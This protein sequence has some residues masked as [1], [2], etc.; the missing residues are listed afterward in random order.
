MAAF[1][2]KSTTD[3]SF[4]RKTKG[5]YKTD[6]GIDISFHYRI[7]LPERLIV[8]KFILGR[9]SR[10]WRETWRFVFSDSFPLPQQDMNKTRRRLSVP[11]DNAINTELL[12][13]NDDEAEKIE[14]RKS[15]P[16]SSF[17]TTILKQTAQNKDTNKSHA[18]KQNS[19]STQSTLTNQQLAELYAN[20][21]KL[22]NENKINQKNTWS[23]KL[24]DYIDDVIAHQENQQDTAIGTNFQA[25]S[26]TLDA[27]VK[28]YSH[29][30]DSVHNAA[31]QMLGGLVRAESKEGEI[32]K[33]DVTSKIQDNET[34]EKE[35]TNQE[36]ES[37]DK[38]AEKLIK[39]GKT[40][41]RGVNT[42]ETNLSN[43]N[44][45]KIDLEFSVDPLFRKTSA[46]FD[47]GGAHGLLLNRL[48]VYNGCTLIFDSSDALDDIN[49]GASVTSPWQATISSNT[50]LIS[51]AET[52]SRI[53]KEIDNLEICPHFRDFKFFEQTKDLQEVT[54]TSENEAHHHNNTDVV[55]AI[56][57]N[58]VGSDNHHAMEENEQKSDFWGGISEVSN[59]IEF[60]EA[61]LQEQIQKQLFPAVANS[62]PT[63]QKG[64]PL[65][66]D[67]L[68]GGNDGKNADYSYFDPKLLQNWAGPAHWKFK[69]RSFSF[70]LFTKNFS[71]NRSLSS[72]SFLT[73]FDILQKRQ[74]MKQQ[75]AC[76]LL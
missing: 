7:N 12:M 16:Q 20:C 58:S 75:K 34:E 4:V 13:Q 53:C 21:L 54:L 23:L 44:A 65:N 40:S 45:K 51:V 72:S 30:V 39:K 27:S 29:R 48:S 6:V 61:E 28:I 25:A 9:F 17:K 3:V 57:L 49:H 52:L 26:C 2:T 74:Q 35:P 46:S 24:I 11:S 62:Q 60:Q 47:E 5:F 76:H 42:L 31:Y 32:E 15:K 18:S 56:S 55:N 10:K 14:R 66:M 19:S 1:H 33:N 69:P 38:S 8:N 22:C 67:S 64:N 63:E 70:T 50:E 41:G 43:I 71:V 68:F 73:C 36:E 59:D 37:D